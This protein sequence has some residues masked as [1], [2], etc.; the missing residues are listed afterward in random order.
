MSSPEFDASAAWQ[1]AALAA[2]LLA[3]DEVYITGGAQAVGALAYGTETIRPVE[4]IVG[5][6]NRFVAEAKR[7][8]FGRVVDALGDFQRIRVG[9]LVDR[10]DGRRQAV[11]FPEPRV[12]LHAE[13]DP[14]APASPLDILREVRDEVSLLKHP[15]YNRLPHSFS[16]IFGGGYAAG[17]YSYKWAEVLDANAFEAFK[18]HGLFDKETAK[19][20]RDNVLSR[21]GTEKPMALYVKFRGREPD[22]GALLRRAGLLGETSN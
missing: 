10:D 22:A 8:L 20:F 3:V 13:F 18:E 14:A 17:Y 21:G 6:G 12:I 2:A 16:H 5:P 9:Q 15:A 11:Q 1:D 4:K 7:Q 19:K